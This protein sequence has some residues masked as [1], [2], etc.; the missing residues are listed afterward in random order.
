MHG[1]MHL[2]SDVCS[3]VRGAQLQVHCGG[4]ISLVVQSQAGGPLFCVLLLTGQHPKIG[5]FQKW[6]FSLFPQKIIAC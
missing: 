3:G 1:E 2:Q 4:E 6:K 5:E